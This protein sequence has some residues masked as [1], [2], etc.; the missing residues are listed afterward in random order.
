MPRVKGGKKKAESGVPAV[1]A[2]RGRPRRKAIKEQG[3][4]YDWCKPG[5]C[6][7]GTVST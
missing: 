5:L 3:K 1:P 7:P 2:K 6:S 4:I